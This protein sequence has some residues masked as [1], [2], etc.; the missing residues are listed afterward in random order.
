MNEKPNTLPK[1]S[2]LLPPLGGQAPELPVAH[3]PVSRP[4]K[5]RYRSLAAAGLSMLVAAYLLYI[6]CHGLSPEHRLGGAELS[7]MFLAGVSV[8]AIVR[9]EDVRGG[10]A[11]ISKISGWGV[12]VELRERVEKQEK[13]VK[14]QQSEVKAINAMLTILLGADNREHLK[15]ISAGKYMHVRSNKLRDQL[16]E[17]ARMKL[18]GRNPGHHI[19]E[20]REIERDAA[21]PEQSKQRLNVNDIVFLSEQ[22]RSIVEQIKNMEAEEA[23][24]DPE[25]AQET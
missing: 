10:V 21:N 24:Q 4:S 2:T 16:R 7:I 12:A 19:R 20:L 18:I 5:G 8:A 22:G 9:P 6:V 15:K 11:A 25:W 17:L 14:R 3:A 1:N 23:Q 13:K